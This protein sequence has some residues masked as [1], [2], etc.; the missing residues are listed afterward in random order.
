[1]IVTERTKLLVQVAASVGRKYA[2]K[3]PALDADEI[4]TE[5]TAQALSEWRHIS[6][7]LDQAAEYKRTEFEV[8]HFLLGERASVYCG[9][10]HYAYMM[11]TATVL[12]TPREV[13]ALLKE[14][15]YNPDSWV[16]PSKDSNHGTAVEAKSVWV[17][18]HDIN[19]ALE[20]VS[21]KAHDAILAAYGPED[22]NLPEPDKRRL[23]EAV[24]QLT[25]ELNRHLNKTP[26]QHEGPGARV[27]MSNADAIYATRKQG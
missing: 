14:Y 12:Y 25:R 1:M 27:A 5:V 24:A 16:T 15:Y 4:A 17:N 7:K 2:S 22:L 13:R 3:Y 21:D 8:L 6:N 19:V 10:Q 11:N 18:L 9:R 26:D 20:R 23:S